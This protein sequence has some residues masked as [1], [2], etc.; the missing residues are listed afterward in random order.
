MVDTSSPHSLC[1][2][3]LEAMLWFSQASKDQIC[4]KERISLWGEGRGMAAQCE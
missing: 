1:R 3:G 4:A 2:S